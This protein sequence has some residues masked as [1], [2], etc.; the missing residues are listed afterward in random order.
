M[1]GSVLSG[2]DRAEYAV[3]PSVLPRTEFVEMDGREILVVEIPKGC[4]PKH[5]WIGQVL[6]E[7]RRRL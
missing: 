3:I 4:P 7:G 1:A 6:T 2:R 5:Q